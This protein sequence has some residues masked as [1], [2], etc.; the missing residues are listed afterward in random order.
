MPISKMIELERV[1][2]VGQSAEEACG[3]IVGSSPKC[4]FLRRSTQ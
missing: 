4:T 2:H 1:G 3:G